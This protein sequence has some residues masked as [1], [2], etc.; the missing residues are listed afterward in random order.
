MVVWLVCVVYAY[1]ALFYDTANVFVALAAEETTKLS[2]RKMKKLAR[3]TVA[4]LKQVPFV[5]RDVPLAADCERV[6]LVKR[7][8]VVEVH[9]VT[10]ADP[11]LLVGLKS[12]RNTVPVP[13]HWCVMA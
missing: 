11:L 5:R 9:D 10:S 8:D 4:E 12:Y 1:R 3:L 6:K 13:R 7:P 2:S